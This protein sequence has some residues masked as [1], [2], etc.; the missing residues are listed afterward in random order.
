METRA[1]ILRES[2][3]LLREKGIAGFS[4]RGVAERVGVTATALYRHFEDKDALLATLLDQGFSTFG[5]Y[6]MRSLSSKTPLERLRHA[7]HAYFDFALEHP[8]D[9][10]LMFMTPC[11]DL[12]LE[13]VSEGA[14]ARMDGTFVFL[15][16]RIKECIETGALAEHDPRSVALHIWATVHGLAALR[17]NGQLDELDELAFRRHVDFTLDRIDAAFAPVHP[18]HR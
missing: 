3:E 13:S 12:G 14:K 4:M 8:R 16:D 2:G 9:Y 18:R 5:Q 17:L 11:R 6:L 7:G 10:A 15:V 1:R